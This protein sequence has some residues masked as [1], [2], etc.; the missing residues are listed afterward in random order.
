[1]E[2][3]YFADKLAE[4]H[5]SV[6]HCLA[7]EHKCKIEQDQVGF[8]CVRKNDGGKLHLLNYGK[9]IAMGQ[10][11]IEKKPLNHFLPGSKTFS[12]ACAGCNFS[13]KHCQNHDISQV[14]KQTQNVPGEFVEPDQVISVAMNSGCKSI[15][16]T[17][18]EPTIFVEY[19]LEVMKLAHNNGLK[20]IWV[21]N[22][23]F[24]VQTFDLIK[25]YLDAINIDLKFADDDQYQEVCNASLEPVKR[26]IEL[27]VAAGIHT[28]VTTLLIS[29]MHDSENQLEFLVESIATVSPLISWHVSRFRPYYQMYDKPVTEKESLIRAI[30]VAKRIGLNYVYADSFAIENGQNSL[31]PSCGQVVISRLGYTTKSYL[32]DSKCA[33]CNTELPIIT[34]C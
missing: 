22:G 34:E 6:V 11:P 21:S 25:P 12:I 9:V 1:M 16:Y 10:D 4:K 24:S 18:T 30:K 13:C 32:K 33:N 5:D 7:C 28:E 3:K 19:A 17:Y 14:V 27:C 31:C 8:C 2:T 15:S 26:N 29:G 20:N 23:Y